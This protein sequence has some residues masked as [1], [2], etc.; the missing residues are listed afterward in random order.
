MG[1]SA[2]YVE[3]ELGQHTCMC[4]GEALEIGVGVALYAGS[5]DVRWFYIG[6]RCPACGLV[7][8][9]ADWKNE[10]SNYRDLLDR[11]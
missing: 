3:A 8:V 11:V 7:G 6:C 2:D 10:F 5:Q 9:Y 1:D 4:D